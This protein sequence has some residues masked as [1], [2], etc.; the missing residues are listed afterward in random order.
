MVLPQA[1]NRVFEILDGAL[2]L[3]DK[4]GLSHPDQLT[5]KIPGVIAR[6]FGC[7]PLCAI[8]IIKLLQLPDQTGNH[9]GRRPITKA[10][11]IGPG[12]RLQCRSILLSLAEIC[13]TQ[14]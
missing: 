1:T 6:S 13:E 2:F 10:G 11:C 4:R 7:L 14:E 8:T 12:E 3:F 9:R 5:S